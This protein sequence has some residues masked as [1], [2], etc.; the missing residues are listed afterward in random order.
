VER[1]IG[2]EVKLKRR[3]SGTEDLYTT[4]FLISKSPSIVEKEVQKGSCQ[5]AKNI[6]KKIINVHD[7][8]QKPQ[9]ENV[10]EQSRTGKDMVLKHS[11]KIFRLTFFAP[12]MPSPEIIQHV[13]IHYGKLNGDEAGE[14][15]VYLYY[16]GEEP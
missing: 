4:I 16:F 10:R 15:V 1:G 3:V 7:F 11:F 2:G 12:I 14:K 5:Y 13:V 8:G 9:D 6:G